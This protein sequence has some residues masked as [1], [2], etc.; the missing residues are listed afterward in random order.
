MTASIRGHQGRFEVYVDGVRESFDTI[1]RFSVNMDS[2]FSRSEYVGNAVAEG[3]QSIQGWSGQFE[4][5]VKDAK[6]DEFIDALINNN[7]NG[8][9]V[10]S[11]F[12]ILTENYANGT[13]ASY[14]YTDCQFKI[15][16]DQSGLSDKVSKRLDFQAAARS[17]L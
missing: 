10:S 4:N 17:R 8:I 9:G 11:Y 14:V 13:T 7:L 16:K 6:H 12:L 15:S 3:D 2:N 1:T 5:E